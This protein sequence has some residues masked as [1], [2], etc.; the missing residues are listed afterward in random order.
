MDQYL[1]EKIN[2]CGYNRFILCL[3]VESIVDTLYEIESSPKIVNHSGQILIDMLFLT[4]NGYNRFISCSFTNGKLDLTKARVVNP[5][6]SFRNMTCKFLHD[7]FEYVRNSILT[8]HQRE[9]IK[10]GISF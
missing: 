9:C 1:I 4:G 6:Q 8:A 5:D 3:S 2:L 10:N 7:H